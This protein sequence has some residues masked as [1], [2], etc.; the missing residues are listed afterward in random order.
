MEFA[1]TIFKKSDISRF[2]RKSTLVELEQ[3]ISTKYIIV[4][5]FSS[6]NID[7]QDDKS[8]HVF[9]SEA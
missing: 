6:I 7:S 2:G 1:L 5:E 9:H 4:W 3:K 8:V